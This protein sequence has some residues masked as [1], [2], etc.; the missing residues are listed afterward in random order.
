MTRMINPAKKISVLFCLSWFAGL[1]IAQ[2]RSVTEADSLP[3]QTIGEVVITA[4][5][6]GTLADKNS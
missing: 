6:Y 5:R 3:E 4:N 2:D 1:L